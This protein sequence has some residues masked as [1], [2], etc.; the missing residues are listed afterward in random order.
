MVAY[1]TYVLHRDRVHRV[2]A[3][4]QT[5]P[6]MGIMKLVTLDCDTRQSA[7]DDSIPSISSGSV[8]SRFVSSTEIE[9]AK[10]RREEQWK[11]AYA[12]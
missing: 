2:H 4:N 5:M 7:M 11:A 8:G 3:L 10:A 1:S 12:R 9:A 6:Y